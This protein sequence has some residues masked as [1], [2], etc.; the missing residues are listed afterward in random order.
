VQQLGYRLV[1]VPEPLI[2]YYLGNVY[3][4]RPSVDWVD[5]VRDLL[6]PEA[7]SGFCLTVAVQ[8]VQQ[9]ERNRA[10]LTLLT[11]ALRRGHPTA[12]RLFAFAMIWMVP[13]RLRRR[14]REFTHRESV[15][16]RTAHGLPAG[17]ARAP[18]LAR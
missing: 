11:K 18:T 17:D 12:K 4:W 10:M 7:Y 14:V 2:T 13:D 15:E 5:S 9:P 1:T 16:R 8:G 6:S 3:A